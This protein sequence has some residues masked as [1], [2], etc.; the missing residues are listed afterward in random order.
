MME[1]GRGREREMNM[2]TAMMEGGRGREREMNVRTAMMER[3]KEMLGEPVFE[4]TML[5]S[6]LSSEEPFITSTLINSD[7]SH[8]FTGMQRHHITSPPTENYN[9]SS[10][11]TFSDLRSPPTLS[12]EFILPQEETHDMHHTPGPLSSLDNIN[13]DP[14]PTENLTG[15][16]TFQSFAPQPPAKLTAP[17]QRPLAPQPSAKLT[18]PPQG[19][20]PQTAPPQR[21][22]APQPSANLTG[23][24][25]GSLPKTAPPQRPLAPQLSAKLTGPPQRALP[26]TASPQK[27]LAPQPLTGPPQGALNDHR[28]PPTVLNKP[29]RG[30]EFLDVSGLCHHLRAVMS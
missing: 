6:Q 8:S 11:P 18:G 22:L 16:P 17:P 28:D 9:F 27:P 21:P 1:G 13:R 19:G 10:P 30:E 2:E 29:S 4:E 26:Q 14:L 24:P 5:N 23:P 12:D 3:G 7:H 15:P 20:L 25:Q